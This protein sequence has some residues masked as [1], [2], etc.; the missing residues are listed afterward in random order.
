MSLPQQS[1]P[2]LPLLQMQQQ[3]HR[4]HA[5]PYALPSKSSPTSPAAAEHRAGRYP[6]RPSLPTW[7]H[8]YAVHPNSLGSEV[9]AVTTQGW[10]MLVASPTTVSATLPTIPQEMM[11]SM[12]ASSTMQPLQSFESLYL[13]RER[14]PTVGPHSTNVAGVYSSH[15]ASPSPSSP[16]SFSSSSSSPCLSASASYS[17]T[18]VITTMEP[19]PQQL[20]QELFHLQTIHSN[21]RMATTMA[22]V[23]K[24]EPEE[25]AIFPL[26]MVSPRVEVSATTTGSRSDGTVAT[27][28]TV[29]TG[30]EA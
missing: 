27:M 1:R 15:P 30:T 4:Y 14:L 16:P 29:T 28:T 23:V 11:H 10:N 20:Q 21:L 5:S 7:H 8:P 24:S 17:T 26:S 18:P 25:N 2:N 22:P 9:A 12:S 6:R 13:L 19:C 3:T